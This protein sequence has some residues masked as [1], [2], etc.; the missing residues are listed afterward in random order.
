MFPGSL[1]IIPWTTFE[2]LWLIYS[3]ILFFLHIRHS[4]RR[5][6]CVCGWWHTCVHCWHGH[7]SDNHWW[8]SWWWP[9]QLEWVRGSIAMQ[10]SKYHQPIVCTK[11]SYQNQKQ[12]CLHDRG[13]TACPQKKSIPRHKEAVT[14]DYTHSYWENHESIS[15]QW[16]AITRY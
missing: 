4:L 10:L 8:S 14:R 11:W 16:E 12:Q 6:I 9:V 5:N 2:A 1:A 7:S 3:K 13:E 15:N